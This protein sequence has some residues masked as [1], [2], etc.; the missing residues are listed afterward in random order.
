MAQLPLL[1]DRP[2]DSPPLRRVAV[3]HHPMV[4]AARE[5]VGE[6]CELL[7]A[8]DMPIRCGSVWDTAE[9]EALLPQ[10]DVCV[11]LGG[12]GSMLRVARLAA[13]HGVPVLGI[14]LG[15]LG[16]LAELEPRET[17]DRLPGILA[18]NYWI[19]ERIMIAAELH[20]DGASLG[21]FDCLNEVV[22]A[23]RQLARVVRVQAAIDGHTMT[24]YTADGVLVATPTGSTA[25]AL[26]AGG[27]ILHPEV[28]NLVLVP[29][30]A[31]LS[32]RSPLVLPA[33]TEVRLTV[34]TD[35]EAGASFD[36]QSDEP[37]LT[38]D[39]VIVRMGRHTARFVR[40]QERSYFYHTLVHKL[41]VAH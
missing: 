34:F 27:P 8:H 2:F 19:E 13:Y 37:L 35:R 15:K 22:V 40:A 20:R 36:G 31:H 21:T 24:T 17:A 23:R 9:V 16:F 33:T 25:Y 28:R 41:R 29:I 38:N 10:V 11:V 26:A 12:D 14:N 6:V 4:R 1:P 7:H 30:S 32:M 5:M 3:L 18:G 39:Q